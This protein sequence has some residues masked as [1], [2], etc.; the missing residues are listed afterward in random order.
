MHYPSYDIVKLAKSVKNSYDKSIVG[1][2]KNFLLNNKD[3]MT[4]TKYT[5]PNWRGSTDETK[6]TISYFYAMKV[7]TGGFDY[8]SIVDPI[9]GKS[10][11]IF[12][13]KGKILLKSYLYKLIGK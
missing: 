5:G 12:S 1:G 10:F 9:T 7:K 8:S 3:H 11:N 4:M 6:T 2:V 13:N